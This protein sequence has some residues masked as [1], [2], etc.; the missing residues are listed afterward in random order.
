MTRSKRFISV[1]ASD[2]Q[3]SAPALLTRKSTRP[4]RS[5]VCFDH[6]ARPR[7]RRARR[8]GPR[9]RAA[10]APRSRARCR[11][12]CPA[13]SDPAT[14]V[15]AATT[16]SQPSAA[17]R[18]ASTLPTPREAPVTT[19]TLFAN[20]ITAEVSPIGP[21]YLAVRPL[22]R[23]PGPWETSR[24]SSAGSLPVESSETRSPAPRHRRA[25]RPRAR[26]APRR[27]FASC[28]RWPASESAAPA[29]ATST[30]HDSRFYGRLLRDA[31][32][33]VGESYMDGW[34]DTDA[35]DVLLEK[36]MRAGLREKIQGSLRL[37]AADRE[38]V[39][40]QP[41]VEGALR[42]NRSRRTTTSATTSTRDA[43]PA[44][45]LHLRLLEERDDAGRGAGGEARSRLPQAGPRSRACACSTSAAAGAASRAWAAEKYGCSVVGV[46]LSKDQHAL[47]T[48]DVEAPRR[49]P[50]PVRLPRRH[51][52]RSTASS[53]IGM[54]EHVGPEESPPRDGG[55]APLPGRRRH[56]GHPHHRQQPQ[57]PPRHA[58]RREVHLPERGRAVARA[59]RQ[60]RPRGCSSSRICTTSAPTTTAR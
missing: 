32:L 27:W 42:R 45:G 41:A 34:W 26:A 58:V 9:A 54:M 35:L 5:S 13:A 40:V 1:S 28:S 30:V 43:R 48:R 16:T 12:W 52:A 3:Y 7:R 36:I 20:C 47:G 49:R 21:A 46:T 29:R 17:S 15:L 59:A 19:A 53:S 57:P 38:G 39:P 25:R 51:A 14:A 18:N 50:A 24:M 33:G 60:A 8:P 22:A 56:R 31:S 11:G 6:R 23:R 2:R 4:N 55:R 44:H 37:R 10:P